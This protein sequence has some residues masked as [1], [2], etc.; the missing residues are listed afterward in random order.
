MNTPSTGT[1]RIWP[2]WWRMAGIDGLIWAVLFIVGAIVLQGETPSRTDS[3]ESIRRYFVDDGNKYL[4]GDFLIMLGFIIF[5]VP[6]IIGF[7]W[8]LG[9]AEGKPA[10][11]SWMAFSGGLMATI[12]GGVAGAGW[13]ALAL[14]LKD[15]P[16]LDDGTIRLIMDMNAVAFSV[17]TLAVALFVGSAGLVI[18]RTGVLWRW[19]GIIG[20]VAAVLLAVGS[21][22]PIDGDDE[23]A[24]AILG[25]IGLP[26]TLIFV[27][28][29]SVGLI[30]KKEAPQIE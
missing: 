17:V 20:L 21:A 10:I 30:M 7:R 3:I 18:F 15:N 23:G 25:F 8:V 5:Y 19:L 28:I 29:S 13:A 14:G 22:W 9:G 4:V 16:E 24:I 2:N 11:W 1:N 27:I 26:A 6:F 12:F